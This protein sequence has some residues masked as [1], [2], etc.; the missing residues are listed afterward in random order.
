MLKYKRISSYLI[1]S[2]S[3]ST[4]VYSRGNYIQPS[5]SPSSKQIY[6]LLCASLF[7][8]QHMFSFSG[9]RSEKMGLQAAN[10]VIKIKCLHWVLSKC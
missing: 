7:C 10:N 4:T 5:I 9:L 6:E 1:T 8:G 2:I 3:I